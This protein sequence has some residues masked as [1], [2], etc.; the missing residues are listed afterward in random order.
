MEILIGVLASIMVVFLVL[1][2]QAEDDW[3]HDSTR[4]TSPPDP[5]AD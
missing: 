1:G 2:G 4:N 3:R 5:K